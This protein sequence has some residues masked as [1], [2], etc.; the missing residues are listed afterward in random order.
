MCKL[1]VLLNKLGNLSPESLLPFFEVILQWS[2]SFLVTFAF[3]RKIF[4]KLVSYGHLQH[5][6]LNIPANQVPHVTVNLQIQQK[7]CSKISIFKAVTLKLKQ[8]IFLQIKH[9]MK[10]Y[11]S[12]FSR[13]VSA[14]QVSYEA[15]TL[16]PNRNILAKQASNETA[17]LEI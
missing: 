5:F 8:K 3:G 2:P 12:K 10:R 15:V 1:A 9:P 11:P 7:Y 6:A 17:T 14:M 4:R 16:R 13:T